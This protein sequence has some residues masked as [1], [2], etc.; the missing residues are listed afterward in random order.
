[1]VWWHAGSADQA[2]DVKPMPTSLTEWIKTT[3]VDYVHQRFQPFIDSSD[4]PNVDEILRL[5]SID[6]STATPELCATSLVSDMRATCPLDEM[7]R[8]AANVSQ[9]PVYRFQV[10]GNICTVSPAIDSWSCLVLQG[11]NNNNIPGISSTFLRSQFSLA[12]CF[13]VNTFDS[14]REFY[15]CIQLLLILL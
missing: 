7:A 9:S 6:T 3:Y 4:I 8:V 14:I 2:N 5:Y 1:M 11:V 12:A 10:C 15:L 13:I